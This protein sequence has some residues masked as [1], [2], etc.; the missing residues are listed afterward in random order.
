MC[1]TAS[2]YGFRNLL[3]PIKTIT[4][5]KPLLWSIISF[6]IAQN[7]MAQRL[8]EISYRTKMSHSQAYP[9]PLQEKGDITAVLHRQDSDYWYF[10]AIPTQQRY[11]QLSR[12]MYKMYHLMLGDTIVYDSRWDISFRIKQVRIN[13]TVRRFKR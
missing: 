3:S 12:K 9:Q 4:M 2:S 5:I 10:R 11:I 6:V 7:C 8:S 1:Y 13:R